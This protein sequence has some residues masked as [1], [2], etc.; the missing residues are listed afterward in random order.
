M[1]R[2]AHLAGEADIAHGVRGAVGIRPV[3]D[4]VLGEQFG[5]GQATTFV[6]ANV[7]RPGL[8]PER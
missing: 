1:L 5:S 7:A 6:A 8:D 3:C 4:E 2:L